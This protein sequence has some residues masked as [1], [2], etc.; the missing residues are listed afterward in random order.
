MKNFL[1][2]LSI[3]L[4]NSIYSCDCGVE[5]VVN[6]F[7]HSTFV[8]KGKIIK[9][10]NNLKGENIYKADIEIKD[11]YKGS[12]VKSVF[13]YGRSDN[14]IGTSCDI[15]IPEGTELILY[16]H[17]DKFN[18]LIIGM[19]SGLLYLNRKTYYSKEKKTRELKMLKSLSKLKEK[20]INKVK[21]YSS[22][23]SDSLATLKG[24]DSKKKYGVYKLKFSKKLKLKDI[25]TVDGFTE[26]SIDKR[27]KRILTN[28]TWELLKD[29][30]SVK[31]ESNYNY[32]IDIYHYPK[33]KKNKSFY[34]KFN[35]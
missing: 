34:T 30:D 21:L 27:V 8:A 17:K 19:C 12:K 5:T 35:L 9:N 15:F 32:F 33:D 18:R 25:K 23:L 1:F 16:A 7:A 3:L 26:K 20:D 24:V 29:R 28:T 11:L 10:Y 31:L 6:K 4:S 14:K 13:V 2:C 22:E